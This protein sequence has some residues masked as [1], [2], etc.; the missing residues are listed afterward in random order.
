MV[1]SLSPA[2]SVCPVT[3]APAWDTPCTATVLSCCVT[4]VMALADVNV[5]PSLPMTIA[6]ELVPS[7]RMPS[8]ISTGMLIRT[9]S[10]NSEPVFIIMSFTLKPIFLSIIKRYPRISVNS[11]ILAISVPSAAP[12]TSSLG[13]PNLPKIKV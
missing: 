11:N 9:Y 2:P 10:Q 1:F 13:A 3:M 12:A 6:T 7:A 4:A 5:A 8:L